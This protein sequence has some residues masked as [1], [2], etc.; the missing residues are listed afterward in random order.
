[1]NAIVAD[2]RVAAQEGVSLSRLYLLRALY[3]VWAVGV[4]IKVWPRFFP[5][6]LSLP[7]MNTVVN[8]VLAGL[9]LTALL[10]VRYPL[11]MLPLMFFE[12]AWKAIWLIAVGLPLWHTGSFDAATTDV[13]KAIATVVVFPFAIPWRYA[14]DHYLKKPGDRWQ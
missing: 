8:S 14:I 6:N 9:S 12:I 1:M 10:G 5:V 13:F 4:A 2:E 11:R 3:L 7:V